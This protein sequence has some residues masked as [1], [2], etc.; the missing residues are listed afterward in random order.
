MKL[1]DLVRAMIPD[2]AMEWLRARRKRLKKRRVAARPPISEERMR[3][4]FV[5]DLGLRPGDTVFV[6]TAMG[7]LN[8]AMPPERILDVLRDVIGSEG[9]MLFPTYPPGV[10]HEFLE[11]GE[12]FDVRTSPSYTG[13]LTEIARRQPDAVRSLHPTKS[14]CAIGPR[15]VEL[16]GTHPDSPWPYDA[17]SPYA[18]IMEHG[19]KVIGIG[20]ATRNL[21]FVHCVDDFLKD[22]FPVR[23]YLDHVFE[24]RCINYDGGVEIVRTYAH[25]MSKI[26]FDV[27]GFMRAHVARPIC[28][29][30]TICGAPFFRADAGPLFQ[31]MVELARDGITI[32]PPLA[33]ERPARRQR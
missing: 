32:Y 23:P 7:E 31:R 2:A 27:P 30:L 8:L 3:T 16:T 4:I 28:E 24:A 14:A 33:Y 22:E 26:D 18:K 11:S 10:A 21:S 9:T 6:H 15:A 13:L 5:D 29:D 19:G 12:V 25:D 17:N 20:V 1:T